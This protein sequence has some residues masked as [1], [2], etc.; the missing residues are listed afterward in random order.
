MAA[1]GDG[2]GVVEELPVM[3][4]ELEDG[5]VGVGRLIMR[6]Q[7]GQEETVENQ[8]ARQCA[9]TA[10]PTGDGSRGVDQVRNHETF[11]RKGGERADDQ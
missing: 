5:A 1:A 9:W 10:F 8:V 4:P 6:W 3:E 7:V 11:S 2:S